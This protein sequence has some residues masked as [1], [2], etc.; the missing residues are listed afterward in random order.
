MFDFIAALNEVGDT[1]DFHEG[2]DGW[3]SYVIHREAG[4]YVLS[5]EFTA[6]D[7]EKGGPGEPIVSRYKLTEM[8]D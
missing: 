1:N 8:V 3:L 4:E 5:A 2:L 6:W 7:E